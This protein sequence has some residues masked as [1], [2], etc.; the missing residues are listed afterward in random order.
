VAAIYLRSSDA[1]AIADARQVLPAAKVHPLSC[2]YVALV[3]FYANLGRH[4]PQNERSSE[5]A[6]PRSDFLC[7]AMLDARFAGASSVEPLPFET[8]LNP[9]PA[10]SPK[11]HPSPA[12]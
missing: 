10:S 8:G 9:Q 11:P 5:A 12:S 1:V 6:T 4:A 2:L 7:P 3:R